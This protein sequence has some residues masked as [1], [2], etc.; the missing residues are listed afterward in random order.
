LALIRHQDLDA[1]LAA[2]QETDAPAVY[3]I[4]GEPFLVQRTLDR[5]L[6]TLLPEGMAYDYENLDGA[7]AEIREAVQKVATFSL[8]SKQK[9]VALLDAKVFY[10]KTD[11]DALL[12]KAK[13][14]MARQEMRQAAR[15]FISW[16]AVS[17]LTFETLSEG[18]SG[19]GDAAKPA[20]DALEG[21]LEP[22][23]RFCQ[24]T[25]FSVP[26]VKSDAA[27]LGE[28]VRRGFPKGNAL[29]LTA[30]RVDRRQT[31]FQTVVEE[32]LA[33]D[34]S[35]PTGSSAADR[36]ARDLILETIV[37]ERLSLRKKS[38]DREA[39]GALCEM[40]GFDL[41]VL[42]ENLEKL[43]AYTGTRDR[44]T[45]KDVQ[46]VLSR[47][48]TDPIFE[49][50]GAILERSAEKAL[51]VLDSLLKTGFHPIAVLSALVNQVRKLMIIKDFIERQPEGTWR[52]GY[53]FTAFKARVLPRLAA[54]EKTIREAA[55]HWEN[56]GPG[57]P[58][59]ESGKKKAAALSDVMLAGGGTN[60][61]PVFKLF[62]ASDLFEKE[63]LTDAF[64]LLRETDRLLK[65][66]PLPPRLLL[67]KV[68]LALC[69]EKSKPPIPA[70][71]GR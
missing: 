65:S 41:A 25:G 28:A 31:L 56:L 46:A 57:S 70:E 27:M 49:L 3:L 20:V 39:Y 22:I 62:I 12:E 24:E 60:P 9:V 54:D 50:T 48:K 40:T 11:S 18:L 15:Y 55:E 51:F 36:K 29:I 53:D 37:R 68:L 7:V 71:G 16:M 61:Y 67:E 8:F 30:N 17:R 2:L 26:D 64:P 58:R 6:K 19:S 59:A 13:E 66:T 42:S 44:I 45:L 43:A 33:V 10:S 4:F 1:A 69:G 63:T 38:M 35:V 21:L 23:I 32:G 34:C 14:S 5:L 52:K 47:T